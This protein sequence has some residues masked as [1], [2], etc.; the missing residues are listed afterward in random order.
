MPKS[1]KVE[2]T[3]KARNKQASC[4]LAGSVRSTANAQICV[5]NNTLATFGEIDEIRICI[6]TYRLCAESARDT[7]VATRLFARDGI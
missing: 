5:E 7:N 6:R 2:I 3:H 1:E 4:Y